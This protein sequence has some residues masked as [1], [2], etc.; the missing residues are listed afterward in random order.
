MNTPWC[1]L[2]LNDD[3]GVRQSI[4]LCG[5]SELNRYNGRCYYFLTLSGKAL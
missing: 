2:I 5:F 3:P 1:V 4:R